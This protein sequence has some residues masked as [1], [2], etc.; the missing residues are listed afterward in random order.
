[1]LSEHMDIMFTDTGWAGCV[2]VRVFCSD[3]I[4]LDQLSS[5]WWSTQREPNLFRGWM[6][7]EEEAYLDEQ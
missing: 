6:G 3:N 4:Y 5:R 2:H 7:E 1:M